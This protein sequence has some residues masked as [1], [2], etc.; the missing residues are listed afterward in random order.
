[1][2]TVH[3]PKEKGVFMASAVGILF[4]VNEHTVKL[5]QSEEQLIDKF[6][7]SMQWDQKDPVVNEIAYGDLMKMVDFSNRWVYNGS[8]TTPPCATKVLWNEL[9]TVY[10]MKQKHLD[11]F[12]TKLDLAHG[13]EPST[14]S[15]VG[16]YRDT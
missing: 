15:K 8:V 6:F 10:P 14:L 9:A 1:M 16:S 4:S 5:S 12:K 11:L 3:L 13:Y 2:H 7:D